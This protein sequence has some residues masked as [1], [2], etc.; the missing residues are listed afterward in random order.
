M[1]R[2]LLCL[3]LALAPVQLSEQFTTFIPPR[4]ITRDSI[5]AVVA[6]QQKAQADSNARAS[7]Q[8]MKTWVDSAS[9]VT[10]P[11][12]TVVDSAGR[13]VIVDSTRATLRSGARAPATAS[14][15]PTIIL[16]GLSCFGA[17]AMMLSGASGR[18]PR[19]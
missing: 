13:A 4:N 7:I 3:V 11:A 2:C 6:T 15:L 19:A 18:R 1:R 12:A 8:N 16:L 10:L 14:L 9:G 5:K 17:G